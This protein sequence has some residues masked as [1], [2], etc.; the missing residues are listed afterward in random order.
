MIFADFSNHNLSLGG[1]SNIEEPTLWWRVYTNLN[2]ITLNTLVT[3]LTHHSPR[4][5]ILADSGPRTEHPIPASF[6]ANCNCMTYPNTMLLWLRLRE[7]G[8]TFEIRQMTS[9]CREQ[10]DFRGWCLKPK[11]GES[12]FPSYGSKSLTRIGN[13]KQTANREDTELGFER[14]SPAL[15][16]I[17]GGHRRFEDPREDSDM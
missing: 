9:G 8:I 13:L 15:Q 2:S 7:A 1:R 6:P 5:W 10:P 17:G 14:V 12:R 3:L 4:F 11:V 16:K